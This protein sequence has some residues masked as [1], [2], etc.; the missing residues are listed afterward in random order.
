MFSA[1]PVFETVTEAL[2]TESEIWFYTTYKLINYSATSCIFS[3]A[4]Y[5]ENPIKSDFNIDIP[6]N[7]CPLT[8]CT[9]SSICTLVLLLC[10]GSESL[11]DGPLIQT[12]FLPCLDSDNQFWPSYLYATRCRYSTCCDPLNNFGT[13][14]FRKRR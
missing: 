1:K 12:S 4:S 13:Q 11:P 6:F 14:V 8:T 5:T 2:L 7:H 9:G 10:S 3:G